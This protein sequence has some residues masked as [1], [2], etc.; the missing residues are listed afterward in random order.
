MKSEGYIEILG[1]KYGSEWR[2]SAHYYRK[3]GKVFYFCF[4][5]TGSLPQELW[6]YVNR[7]PKDP[8]M[9]MIADHPALRRM[10]IDDASKLGIAQT[11]LPGEY[12]I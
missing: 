8:N 1:I 10:L 5:I 12:L 7:L 6:K 2:I 11:Y 4:S 9:W 3:N